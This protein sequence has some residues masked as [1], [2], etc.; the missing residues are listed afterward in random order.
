VAALGEA[1]TENAV[2]ETAAAPPIDDVADS[3]RV[4]ERGQRRER[5]E[6]ERGEQ[7]GAG[8]PGSGFNAKSYFE[9]V[10]LNADGKLTGAEITGRLRDNLAQVDTDKD[11]AVTLEEFEAGIRE[12]FARGGGRGRDRDPRQ[13]RPDRLQRPDWEA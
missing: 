4:R 1:P 3:N 6:G 7:R 2:A 10:D 9:S 11:E 5:G 8:G 13:G 12:L